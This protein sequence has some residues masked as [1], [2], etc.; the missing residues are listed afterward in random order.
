MLT[1]IDRTV[2]VRILAPG[3]GDQDT[4]AVLRYHREDPLAVYLT[5]PASVS[6]DGTD[7]TWTFARS[8]LTAGLRAPSGDGD[9]HIWP[10]D[11]GHTMIELRGREGIALIDLVMADLHTFLSRAYEAVPAGQEVHHLDVDAALAALLDDDW[12]LDDD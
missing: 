7:V 8:L 4:T 6:L 1:D 12:L 3:S 5:F 2:R 10:Y 11:P 9:V